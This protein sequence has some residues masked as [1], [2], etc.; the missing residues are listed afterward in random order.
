MKEILAQAG[1]E[2]LRAFGAALVILAPGVL[3]APNYNQM[4]LLGVSA[5][6]AAVAAGLKAVQAFVPAITFAAFISQPLAAW[7]DAFVRAFLAS[8][9]V[10]AVGL[11]SAPELDFDKAV[12]TAAI[13]AAVSAGFRALEGLLTK[14]EDPAPSTG[15]TPVGEAPNN[16]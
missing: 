14:G 1:R 3:A 16:V 11:L 12:I 5:L 13:V 2:F 6:A 10:F 8:V 4:F 9:L 15:V 7:I